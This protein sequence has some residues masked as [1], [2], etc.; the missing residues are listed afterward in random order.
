MGPFKIL[1][2]KIEAKKELND[3]SGISRERVSPTQRQ[4]PLLLQHIAS[5]LDLKLFMLL[6][7]HHL[8]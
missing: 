5:Q 8:Y 3:W 2:T 1:W 6:F 4:L 7:H